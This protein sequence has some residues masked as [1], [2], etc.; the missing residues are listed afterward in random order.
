[1]RVER[2]AKQAANAVEFILW[3]FF[4]FKSFKFHDVVMR[5]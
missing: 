4:V 2:R 1:V 5:V 3:H